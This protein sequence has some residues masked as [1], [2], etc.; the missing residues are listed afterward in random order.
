MIEE[1]KIRIW[2]TNPTYLAKELE[3]KYL[4]LGKVFREK[5]ANQ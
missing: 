4:K 1:V 3:L 5:K 2:E